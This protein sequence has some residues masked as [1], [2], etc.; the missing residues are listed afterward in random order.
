MADVPLQRRGPLARIA[1]QTSWAAQAV[2]SPR[3]DRPHRDIVSSVDDTNNARVAPSGRFVLRIPPTLHAVL[4]DAAN[5][6]GLSLNEYC[7]RSLAAP[8]PDPAGP[9]AA[10]AARAGEA[11]GADLV[12]IILYGS[13]A[14]GEATAGSDIDV[15]VALE[16]TRPITRTLYQEWDRTPLEHDGHAVETHFVSMPATVDEP[17]T[18]WLEV[19]L[20]GVIVFDREGRI[21]RYLSRVRR[22]IANGT[23]VRRRAHGQPYWTAT[24]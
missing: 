6:A 3:A 9:G 10:V 2:G 8:G 18:V 5:S 1:T 4:R 20:D 12:G 15:L 11:F 16:P 24:S 7:V 21:T 13:W 14:R 17:G 19:A 22:D 23:L